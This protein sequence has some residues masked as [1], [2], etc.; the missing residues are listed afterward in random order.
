MAAKLLGWAGSDRA[1]DLNCG[2]SETAEGQYVF[3]I[4]ALG[5]RGH[6]DI[7]QGF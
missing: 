6:R 5:V 2:Y 7:N 1:K 3:S 4:D